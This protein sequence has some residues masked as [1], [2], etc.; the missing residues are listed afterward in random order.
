MNKNIPKVQNV[1]N[2]T[3]LNLGNNQ[4]IKKTLFNPLEI[5]STLTTNF[6]ENEKI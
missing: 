2:G 5:N 4:N 1:N 6:T 3:Q